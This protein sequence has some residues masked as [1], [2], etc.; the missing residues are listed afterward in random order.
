MPTAL[1]ARVFDTQANQHF[2]KTFERF[3]VRIGRNPLND[4]HI[5]RPYV[6]QFHASIDLRD[7][8]ILLRDLGSTNGTLYGGQR[9]ARDQPVDVTASPEVNIGPI[10]LRIG[11]MELAAKKREGSL[12][13]YNENATNAS[14]LLARSKPIQPGGEDPFVRQVAPYLEAYRQAWG[15]AYR[16]VWDHVARL[17]PDLRTSYI[18]R[19]A[20]EHPQVTLEGDFQ[21]LAQWAGVDVNQ[22]GELTA[23]TAAIIAIEELFRAFVPSGKPPEDVPGTLAF[24]RRLRDTLEVFLKCFIPL[25][26]GYQAFEEG[27][28]ERD[29]ESLVSDRVAMAKDPKELGSILLGPGGGPEAMRQLREIFVEVMSHQV[30]LLNGVMVGVK[31]LLHDLA[32]R[33]IEEEFEKRGKKGGLFSSKGEALWKFY[34]SRHGDYSNEDKQLFKTIFGRQF[35]TAYD[36]AVD[37]DF[38]KPPE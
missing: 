37:E 5:D 20:L 33:T 25:R 26:E 24:A 8:Q 15:A 38:G 13:D 29:R 3:P 22:I 2:E 4:L 9:L 23:Q 17:P 21:K 35:A 1:V 19:L 18:R 11:T 7:G 34:E 16:V 36:K 27:V 10:V 28:L 30:A 31:T 12:L 14:A 6:S 32:P